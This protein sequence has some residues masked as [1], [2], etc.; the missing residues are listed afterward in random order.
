MDRWRDKSKEKLDPLAAIPGKKCVGLQFIP[1]KPRNKVATCFAGHFYIIKKAKQ[2][3]V[4]H[5]NPCMECGNINAKNMRKVIAN[6]HI[7]DK[8]LLISCDDKCI[9][10]VGVPGNPL[11]LVPKSEASW[12]STSV[13]VK[14]VDNDAFIKSNVVPSAM[15]AMDIPND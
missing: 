5:D 4:Q 3:D 11:A 7:K 13:E 14:A 6:A 15:F 1:N 12:M 9:V 10:K 8:M 2:K